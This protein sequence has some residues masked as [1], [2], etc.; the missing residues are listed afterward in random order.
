M[1]FEYHNIIGLT[2]SSNF[3]GFEKIYVYI[4]NLAKTF[5]MMEMKFIS[6]YL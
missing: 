3:G 1:Y 6:N 5:Y 2:S 4:V